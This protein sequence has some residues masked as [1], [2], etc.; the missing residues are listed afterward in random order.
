MLA[1][2]SSVCLFF[3]NNIVIK[4]TRK[5]TMFHSKRERLQGKYIAYTYYLRN[6]TSHDEFA[7][8]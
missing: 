3:L 8:S 5:K 1:T 2:I 6:F 4:Y 7:R